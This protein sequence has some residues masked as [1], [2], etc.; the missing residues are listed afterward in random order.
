MICAM[1]ER[2]LG[3]TAIVIAGVL[4]GIIGKILGV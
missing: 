1:S 4:W 3:Y 2:L